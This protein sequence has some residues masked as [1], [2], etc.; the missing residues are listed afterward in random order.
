[1]WHTQA[2][3]HHISPP[4]GKKSRVKCSEWRI[5]SKRTIQKLKCS[6]SSVKLGNL[7]HIKP[8]NLEHTRGFFTKIVSCDQS[9]IQ[10]CTAEL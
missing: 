2:S 4:R 6:V 10:P 7:Q 8:V 9:G 3:S 1:M 5:Q